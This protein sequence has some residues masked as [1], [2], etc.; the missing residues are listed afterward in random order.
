VELLR[1]YYVMVMV[2]WWCSKGR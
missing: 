2:A 1:V